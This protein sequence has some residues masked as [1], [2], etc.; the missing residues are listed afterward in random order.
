M[1]W[2]KCS[3]LYLIWFLFHYIDGNSSSL[4]I[5]Y[6]WWYDVFWWQQHKQHSVRFNANW[7]NV[8][9]A[10]SNMFLVAITTTT[11]TVNCIHY[12]RKE[13]ERKGRG[14]KFLK[15]QKNFVQISCFYLFF[16]FLPLLFA[17]QICWYCGFFW[18]CVI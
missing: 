12:I 16:L 15:A 11:M 7:I 9:L 1:S 10:T 5:S 8:C 6:W 2:W 4:P 18:M 13:Q 14:K 3:G 17:T